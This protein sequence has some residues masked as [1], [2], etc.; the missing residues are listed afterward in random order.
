MTD[1]LTALRALAEKATPGPW[2]A[3]EDSDEHLAGCPPTMEWLVTATDPGEEFYEEIINWGNRGRREDAEFI[4]AANPSVVL[5][6]LDR[7]ER[8]EAAIK[9]TREAVITG[10]DGGRCGVKEHSKSSAAS[11]GYKR[12]ARFVLAALDTGKATGE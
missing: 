4:A 10:H 11:E 5:A 12:C 3:F 6:L 2:E 1:D 8:A 7:L 9:R